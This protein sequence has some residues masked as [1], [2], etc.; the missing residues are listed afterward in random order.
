MITN[1]VLETIKNR[2]SI[3]KFKAQDVE[4]HTGRSHQI[5]VQLSAVGCPLYGDQK[6]GQKLNRPGQQIAL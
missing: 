6:Y 5:R 1:S 3:R 4:L 2:R